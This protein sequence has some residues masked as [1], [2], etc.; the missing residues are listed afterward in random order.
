M[1]GI[2]CFPTAPQLSF[3]SLK[4]LNGP[5]CC[6]ETPKYNKKKD[7]PTPSFLK[8]AVS[9]LTEILRLFSSTPTRV[10][11]VS[12]VETD[13]VSISCID[14]IL[15]VLKSD[16]EKEYFVTG[17]FTPEVYV[18]DCIFED[19]TIRFRGKA[20]YS[21]NLNLLVPF[22]DQPSIRLQQIKKGNDCD[23]DF[24]VASWKLRTYLKL[25]WKPLI[26]IDG[27]TVYD[28]NNDYQIVRHAESW[29]ISAVEAIGQIFTP[30][31]RSTG[32]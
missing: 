2:W 1:A 11:V 29:N 19:P 22:F 20:L 6:S 4:K 13:E 26:C 12:D 30:T 8:I 21:R 7:M 14:D 9:G 31:F 17:S 5:R 25:P 16:Y 15:D 24:V 28:L 32:N 10:D 23:K 27:S 3:P 18:D